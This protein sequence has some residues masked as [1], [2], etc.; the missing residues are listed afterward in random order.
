LH[1][2]RVYKPDHL[3]IAYSATVKSGAVILSGEI[4]EAR[5]FKLDMLPGPL[6]PF[7]EEVISLAVVRNNQPENGEV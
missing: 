6:L 5:W 4:I 3:A 7:V 1:V 2:S